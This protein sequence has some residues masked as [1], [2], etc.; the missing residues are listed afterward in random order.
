MK[1]TDLDNVKILAK[2]FLEM[3]VVAS[4]WSPAIV[5]HPF[6]NSGFYP[7]RSD[8]GNLRVIDITTPQG[9]KEWKKIMRERID[10]ITSIGELFLYV[11]KPYSMT[12]LKYVQHYLSP[13]DYA[14]MLAECWIRE[15]QPNMNPSITKTELTNMFKRADKKFLMSEREYKKWQDLPEKLTIYRGVTEYNG[16]NIRALSWTTNYDTAK[17]FAGRY[18]EKGK[19][20]QAEIDKKHILAY[21]DQRWESEIIVEPKYLKDI[22]MVE[23]LSLT[24]TIQQ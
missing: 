11:N 13:Q 14:K 15:E 18:G 20:Y 2:I 16:K 17:W 22:E 12:F 3:E 6:A 10:S 1:E 4:E 24:M 7:C 8:D 9:L 5:Q 19:V 23:D 21:I